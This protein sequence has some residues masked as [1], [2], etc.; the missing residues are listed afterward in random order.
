[1][2]LAL[3]AMHLRAALALAL[4]VALA[5]CDLYPNHRA[6]GRSDVTVTGNVEMR[7]GQD[8]RA[9]RN[10]DGEPY[11][12]YIYLNQ[13][14]GQRP[15]VTF[16]FA[17]PLQAV[18]AGTYA[19]VPEGEVTASFTFESERPPSDLGES[20]SIFYGDA[21]GELV[22]ESVDDRYLRGRFEFDA[23]RESAEV[24]VAGTFKA[25][26]QDR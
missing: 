10:Q 21:E 11:R 26:F 22:V 1:M 19:I 18:A 2:S 23:F 3:S 5:G 14:G 8:A 7:F 20:A 6:N 15:R 4:V 17:D 16:R 12:D 25:E 13:E 9:I 24:A